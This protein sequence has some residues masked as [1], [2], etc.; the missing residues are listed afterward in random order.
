MAIL[1]VGP[2]AQFTTIS[3]AVAAA[4]TGDTID[5]QGGTYTNDFPQLIS[6][7]ITL[8]G[9]GG[10]VNLVATQD[11]TRKAYSM[12]APPASPSP[13]I[14]S[15]SQAASSVMALAATAPLSATRA[16]TSH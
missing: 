9:V 6:K 14:I 15:L 10:M 4:N 12:S 7:S 16:A 5:V 11:L 1:T 3:D 8:Q 2:G 13:S